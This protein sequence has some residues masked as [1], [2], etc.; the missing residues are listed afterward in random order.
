MTGTVTS[1][2]VMLSPKARKCVRA[3]C[4]AGATTTLKVQLAV[5][6]AA[7]VAVQPTEVVPTENTWPGAGVQ[8][9]VTGGRPPETAG[10]AK[11]TTAPRSDVAEAATAAGQ[12]RASAPPP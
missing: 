7:S 6:A 8:A 10:R 2:A 3:N 11:P 4:G 5:T 12:V 1:P 9:T